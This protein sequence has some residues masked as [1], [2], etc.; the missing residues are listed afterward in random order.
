MWGLTIK[1][2]EKPKLKLSSIVKS[3]I[4]SRRYFQSIFSVVFIN[5]G[6]VEV[7]SLEFLTNHVLYLTYYK[8]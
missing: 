2:K 7:F 4:N 6:D 1:K 8:N 5:G 3:S